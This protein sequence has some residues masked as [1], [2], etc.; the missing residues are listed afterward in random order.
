V[1]YSF[2]NWVRR[3][4]KALDFTQQELARQVGCSPSLIIK[5]ESDGRRPSR[6][7]AE[8]L[9][10]HLEISPDQREL[11]LKVAR[12]EKMVESLEDVP[13]PSTLQPA[14]FSHPASVPNPT[15]INLPIPLTPLIGREYEL[16]AIIEQIQ[17]PFCRLLTLTGPGGV[18]KTRLSLE[19]A[20]KLQNN[21]ENGAAFISLVGTSAPEFIIPAI[22]DA[23]AFTFSGNQELK[24][25]LFNFLKE[26][27]IFLVLDNLEHL[28]NGI[29]LLDELLESAPDVKLLT[30]SREQLNLRT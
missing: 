30:T 5:I 6:Q 7:V 15:P 26:K 3:R 20:H 11:F 18:G 17:D 1:D 25:Q 21:F 28:L 23:L 22:A 9:A 29:E 2:G 4:R 12:R 8:L 14:S 27:R 24:A 10:D 16:Y 13:P 19:A